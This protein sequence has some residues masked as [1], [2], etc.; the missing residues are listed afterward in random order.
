MARPTWSGSIS[1]GLVSVPVELHTAVRS[2]TIRFKQLHKETKAPVRQKRVDARTGEEVSYDDIVKGYEVDNGRYVVVDPDELSELDPEAS[3]LIC[4]HAYVEQREID[5]LYY[6]RAYY[7]TPDGEVA[8]KPYRLLTEAMQRAG[9]VAIATFVM[10]NR[11]YLAALR[12]HEGMLVLSTMH[13]A[14]EVADPAD[15]NV[16]LG[17]GG[18]LS[19][20]EITMAEQLIDSLLTEFD[21]RDYRDEHRQ[22]VIEF[23][24]AKGEGRSIE[25]DGD[26]GGGG[27]NVVDLMAALEQSLSRAGGASRTAHPDSPRGGSPT[28]GSSEYDGMTRA[29]L[30]ELAR[31]RDL[32]GRSNLSKSELIRALEGD[33]HRAG[34]A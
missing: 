2:H 33:D 30:Y 18:Q 15:L 20:R 8:T 29:A 27:G 12:A 6:D 11:E 26:S 31:E 7:L 5:P 10:R 22:R 19:E 21:P 24:E 25:F 1:F 32:P 3:R 34:A 14:D 28:R 9:K 16:D 23:L 13:Y 17:K 4:I